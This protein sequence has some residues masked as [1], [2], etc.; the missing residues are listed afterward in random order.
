MCEVFLRFC[1]LIIFF[2]SFLSFTNFCK[3]SN[4]MEFFVLF[5]HL[6]GASLNNLQFKNNLMKFCKLFPNKLEFFLFFWIFTSL[7]QLRVKLKILFLRGN[8][9]EISSHVLEFWGHTRSSHEW[10]FT[11]IIFIGSKNRTRDTLLFVYAQLFVRKFSNRNI[12]FRVF[13]FVLF[14][15]KNTL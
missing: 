7:Y 5:C 15:L 10:M 9:H 6:S 13:N 14:I 11:R 1:F 8:S 2:I 3:L 12:L 4:L